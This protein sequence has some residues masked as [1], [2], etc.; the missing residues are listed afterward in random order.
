MNGDGL[1]RTQRMILQAIRDFIAAHGYPPTMRE[2]GVAAD[3]SSVSSVFY[4]LSVL[5]H[6]GYVRWIPNRYRT[7]E[8]VPDS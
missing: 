4:Q 2:V 8:L 5:Q 7:L 1:T 6:A 3:L